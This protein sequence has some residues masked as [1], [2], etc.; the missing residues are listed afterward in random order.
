MED[1]IE[2]SVVVPAYNESV[3]MVESLQGIL[4]YLRP[5][6][7][8]VEIVVVDDGS[9]DDTRTKIAEF[10]ERSPEIRIVAYDRNRGKGYAVRQGMLASKGRRVIISDADLSAPIEDLPL[11]ENALERGCEIAV[12]SRALPGSV[13]T[14]RQPRYREL[15]GKVLNLAIRLLAVP[16]I[17]D[18]Q[19]GFK[20]F[21]GEAARRIFSKCTLDGWGFDVEVLYLARR[22]GYRVAEVPVHWAHREGSKVRPF[23][24]GVKILLDLV[25][26]RLRRYDL[27]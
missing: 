9:T 19:C 13:L 7:T 23:A 20:L 24:D 3:R 21:D 8:R 5:T 4:D 16:G 14:H 15:G 2:L 17:H 11:L 25:R 12:G 26:I 1:G 10:S 6:V 22:M 18:T 27:E